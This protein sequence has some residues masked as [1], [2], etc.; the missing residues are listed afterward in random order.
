MKKLK[1][2]FSFNHG[3]MIKNKRWKRKNERKIHLNSRSN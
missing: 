2:V 1:E 3:D